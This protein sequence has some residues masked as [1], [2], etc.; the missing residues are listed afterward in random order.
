MFTKLNEFKSNNQGLSNQELLEMANITDA[1]SGIDNVVI[2]IGPNP[3]SHGMRIKVSNIPNKIDGSDCFTLT[4]PNFKII[5]KVNKS[6]I[7]N[8]KIEQIKQFVLLNKEVISSYSNFDISTG[9]LIK[10][11]KKIE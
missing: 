4:I 9:E 6:F 10:N 5:G 1:E 8:E 7:D 11:L 3:P 2:W